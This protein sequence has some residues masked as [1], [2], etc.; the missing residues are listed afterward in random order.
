M[1]TL[2]K[3]RIVK[4]VS[5]LKKSTSPRPKN[6]Y[7]QIGVSDRKSLSRAGYKPT[8]GWSKVQRVVDCGL[9]G[10]LHFAFGRTRKSGAC[11]K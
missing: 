5:Q 1:P 11:K 4:Y 3:N 9:V 10:E 2:D 7:A 6:N 8:T